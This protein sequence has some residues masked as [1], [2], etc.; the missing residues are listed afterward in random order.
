MITVKGSDLAKSF[1]RYAQIA[2]REIVRVTTYGRPQV[3]ILSPQE[4]ERLRRQDRQALY[5]SELPEDLRQAIKT[6]EPSAEATQFDYEAS[7]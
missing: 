7:E 5:T 2:Q 6:A 3:V 4:Y 1:G